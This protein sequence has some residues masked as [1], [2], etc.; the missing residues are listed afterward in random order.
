MPRYVLAIYH[1]QDAPEPEELEQIMMA[2][3]A[4]NERMRDAHVFVDSA[5]FEPAALAKVVTTRGDDAE[6]TD[7]PYL[8]GEV[9]MGG[10]WAIE[11]AS[12]GDAIVWADRAS[13]A[14]RL[15][16]EIRALVQDPR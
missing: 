10:F 15:P 13:R 1:D 9:Q 8:P 11:A 12:M 6:V 16:V 7:G 3:D 2:I 5:G 14:V 4:F